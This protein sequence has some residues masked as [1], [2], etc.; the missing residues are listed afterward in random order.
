M[1]IIATRLASQPGSVTRNVAAQSLLMKEENRRTIRPKH[2]YIVF[3][4][5]RWA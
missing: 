1:A 2:A 3:V 5:G 4:S